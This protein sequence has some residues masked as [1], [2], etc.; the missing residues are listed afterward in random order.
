M[1]AN[2]LQRPGRQ[3]KYLKMKRFGLFNTI[4]PSDSDK[5]CILF[6]SLACYRCLIL[7]SLDT[8]TKVG[9]LE[10]R[11]SLFQVFVMLGFDTTSV[12]D[13]RPDEGEDIDPESFEFKVFS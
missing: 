10:L 5:R 9:L 8:S 13:T 12:K 11:F 4:R 1:A 2:I 6:K 3:E 7:D